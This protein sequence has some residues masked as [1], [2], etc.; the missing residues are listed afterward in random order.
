MVE[1][2][3]N[4]I[5]YMSEHNQTSLVLCLWILM[6]DTPQTLNISH[7]KKC[8]KSEWLKNGHQIQLLILINLVS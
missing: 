1:M 3:K 4:E 8:Q 7:I 2:R 6:H 5:I